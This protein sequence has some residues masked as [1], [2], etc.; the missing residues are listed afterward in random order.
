MDASQSNVRKFQVLNGVVIMRNW[1]L[2]GVFSLCG[3]LAS[4][5]SGQ[6]VNGICRSVARVVQR[7]PDPIPDPYPNATIVNRSVASVTST[8]FGNHS[9]AS[10]VNR[11]AFAH[12]PIPR[13]FSKQGIGFST[14]SPRDAMRNS[15]YWNSGRSRSVSVMKVNGGWIARVNY[16]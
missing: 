3:L 14:R 5:A 6:C 1:I 11:V 4:E 16:K 10:S 15:C 7:M 2:L 12:T 13:G 9:R 8:P